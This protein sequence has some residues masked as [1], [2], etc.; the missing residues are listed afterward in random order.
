MILLPVPPKCSNLLCSIHF[1]WGWGAGGWKS[2][3]GSHSSPLSGLSSPAFCFLKVYT[4]LI[5]L[6]F[7]SFLHWKCWFL[8][9]SCCV[10][11]VFLCV[12]HGCCNRSGNIVFV[13]CYKYNKEVRR[14]SSDESPQGFDTEFLLG[15]DSEI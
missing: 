11:F 10:L 14:L 7:T 6:S 13:S 2:S 15:C 8:V 4:A 12:H 1:V 9:H 3:P 5:T